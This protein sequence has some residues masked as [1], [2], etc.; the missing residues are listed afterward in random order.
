M[1]R[2]S[3]KIDKDINHT[4]IKLKSH[5]RESYKPKSSSDGDE[6]ENLAAEMCFDR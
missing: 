4:L 6:A 3:N 2:S 1:M 5:F